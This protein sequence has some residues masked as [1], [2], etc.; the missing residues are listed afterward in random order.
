MD[1][2]WRA[3]VTQVVIM[4]WLYLSAVLYSWTVRAKS[5]SPPTNCSERGTYINGFNHDYL[6]CLLGC[7]LCNFDSIIVPVNKLHGHHSFHCTGER[8]RGNGKLRTND[9]KIKKEGENKT[10]RGA[11]GGDKG[12]E[13]VKVSQLT[14]FLQQG[15][16]TWQV[17]VHGSFFPTSNISFSLSF[18]FA[19]LYSYILLCY[20]QKHVD[21]GLTLKPPVW[22]HAQCTVCQGI[23]YNWRCC[24]EGSRRG[25]SDTS[26]PWCLA[27]PAKTQEWF[28]GLLR[29]NEETI[30]PQDSTLVHS[31]CRSC[32]VKKKGIFFFFSG[33]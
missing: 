20:F 17:Q 16:S 22:V 5:I 2:L 18:P 12:E 15:S 14:R 24:Y 7:L 8:V 1:K 33:S 30:S 27:H 11:G 29:H 25:M 23:P 19:I 31:S 32:L 4:C 21:S 9:E 3:G 10:G 28:R 13:I 6:I 26:H